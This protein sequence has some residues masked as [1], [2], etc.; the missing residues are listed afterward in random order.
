MRH[1]P[2][3]PQLRA[4]SSSSCRHLALRLACRR[5]VSHLLRASSRPIASA[6]TEQI[7]TQTLA[8]TAPPPPPPPPPPTPLRFVLSTGARTTSAAHAAWDALVLPGDF[9]VDAT[10]GNGHDTL[11]LARLVGSSGSVLAL[12]TNPLAL[13]STR[14]KIEEE[15]F[16]RR[17]CG[18]DPLGRVDLVLGCH[19]RLE[20]ALRERERRRRRRR[21]S[22]RFQEEA[23][24]VGENDEERLSVWSLGEKGREEEEE[25][26]EEGEERYS[27]SL[28]PVALA[29]FNLGYLPEFDD[30]SSGNDGETDAEAAPPPPPPLLDEKAQ[31]ATATKPDTTVLAIEAAASLLAPGGTVSICSYF[32]HRGGGEEALAVQR[33]LRPF[34]PRV[35]TCVES[36]VLNR[37][38]APSLT[39]CYRSTRPKR[40]GKNREK[41]G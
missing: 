12:D 35:W 31:L 7:E 40:K 38:E 15:I 37:P 16:R 17:A 41:G 36:R 9:V 20:E 33:A 18:A 2:Q 1:S 4:M 29:A 27:S 14:T 34:D 8:T 3:P 10:A 24:N 23:E 13:A 11:K 28:P 5:E 32:Q 22:R 25:E 26:A 19:S 21:R 39:L 6:S 30:F